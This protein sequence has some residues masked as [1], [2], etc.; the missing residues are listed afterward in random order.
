LAQWEATG[1]LLRGWGLAE[2]GYGEEGMIQMCQGMAAY[3]A[4]GSQ[5]GLPHY[6]SLLAEVYTKIGQREE[7][8]H[9][10]A[11][12]HS[13]VHKTGGRYCEAELYWLHGE[14]LLWPSRELG[15]PS[16]PLRKK[17]RLVCMRP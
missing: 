6:L 4:T 17:L 13:V 1:K 15:L 7:A 12:A 14:F 11:E 8:R 10:L 9:T 3:R 5:L 2:Q 16:A